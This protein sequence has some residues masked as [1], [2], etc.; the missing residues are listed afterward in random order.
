MSK[1]C[2]IARQASVYSWEDDVQREAAIQQ[3]QAFCSASIHNLGLESF[4]PMLLKGAVSN[5]PAAEKWSLDWLVE[6]FGDQR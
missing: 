4:Q 1:L 2:R 3:L 6:H 5:W